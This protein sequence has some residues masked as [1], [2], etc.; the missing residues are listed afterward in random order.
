MKEIEAEVFKAEYN[1]IK[2]NYSRPI[3]ED[4]PGILIIN[5]KNGVESTHIIKKW[6]IT[7]VMQYIESM[8]NLV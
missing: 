3:L 1:G 5:T 7:R 8:I 2:F 6:A 4:A